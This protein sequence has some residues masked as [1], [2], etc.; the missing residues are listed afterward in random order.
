MRK[1]LLTIFSVLIGTAL[2]AQMPNIG[3]RVGLTSSE[4]SSNLSESFTPENTLGYQAGAFLRLNFTKLYV[5][6]ELIYNHRSTKLEY[7]LKPVVGF[8]GVGVRSEMKIGTFDIPVLVGFKLVSTPLMNIRFFVGPELS[9]ATNKDFSY[10]YISNDGQTVSGDVP[11]NEQLS[12]DDF[13]NVTWYVQAGAGID[14]LFLT[15]DV[16]YEKGLNNVFEGGVGD[17]G[18]IDLKNNVWVFTLGFKFM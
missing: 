2:L 10:E 17:F 5:Q 13:N 6:P 4:L 18:N 1:L 14:L 11:E 12:V 16:R 7:E 15:F 3:V 9:L 8:D